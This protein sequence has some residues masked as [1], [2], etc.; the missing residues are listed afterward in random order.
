MAEETMEQAAQPQVGDSQDSTPDVPT[1]ES[2]QAELAKVRA[3]SRKW[4]KRAKENKDAALRIAEIEGAQ[5]ASQSDVEEAKAQAQA[6]IAELEAMKEAKRRE[7]SIRA[8]AKAVGVDAD[9]LSMMAGDSDEEIQANAAVLQEKLANLRKYPDVNDAGGVDAP[10]VTKES[11]ASIKNP[12]E[13]FEAIKQNVS[14]FK[15]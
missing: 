14:L 10:T 1:V 13:R 4:E 9:L 6:A 12:N 3:E 5:Q 15:K 7:D 8:V 2:L 11:I